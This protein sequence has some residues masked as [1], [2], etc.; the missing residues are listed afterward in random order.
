MRGAIDIRMIPVT[1]VFPRNVIPLV[2]F[3]GAVHTNVPLGSV[4]VSQSA[5]GQLLRI[6]CTPPE[7]AAE[8]VEQPPDNAPSLLSD[9]SE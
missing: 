1:V 8:L 3:N 7:G 5:T 9:P 6:H 2:I 4:I